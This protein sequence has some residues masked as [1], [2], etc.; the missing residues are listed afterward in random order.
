MNPKHTMTT[1]SNTKP[2][3]LQDAVDY[4]ETA[5][6]TFEHDPADSEFQLGYEQALRD[7]ITEFL[8]RLLLPWVH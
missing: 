5:L 6:A 7:T 2:A 8:G 1:T 3:T 4:L